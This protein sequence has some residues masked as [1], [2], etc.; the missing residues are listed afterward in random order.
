MT[1][2]MEPMEPM[3]APMTEEEMFELE[4]AQELVA[5]L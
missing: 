2:M 4:Y 3:D 5:G 1:T